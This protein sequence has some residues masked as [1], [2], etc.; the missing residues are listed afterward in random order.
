MLLL[1]FFFWD[2]GNGIIIK[3]TAGYK[4]VYKNNV[5]TQTRIH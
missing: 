1:L 4:E 5:I 3:Y 2:V